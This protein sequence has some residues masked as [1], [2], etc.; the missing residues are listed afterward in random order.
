MIEAYKCEF[1]WFLPISCVSFSPL[2]R[3]I[4]FRDT[5]Q[6]TIDCTTQ[7]L[8]VLPERE[9]IRD[10]KGKRMRAK[11][12]RKC[13]YQRR[14]RRKSIVVREVEGKLR[15]ERANCRPANCSFT[16]LLA[17][18]CF[19]LL[20]KWRI[21]KSFSRK[22]SLA[23]PALPI[24]QSLLPFPQTTVAALSLSPTAARSRNLLPSSSI[25]PLVRPLHI[26][27]LYTLLYASLK[28]GLKKRDRANSTLT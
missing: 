16:Q 18:V 27:C 8:A 19:V 6:V 7:W 5:H 15:V 3:P 21:R 12:A 10:L 14:R 28:T 11:E 20:T 9:R 23:F 17:P 22:L 24:L 26:T 4:D 1:V 13:R 2:N 25:N